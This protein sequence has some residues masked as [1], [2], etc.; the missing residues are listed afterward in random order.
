MPHLTRHNVDGLKAKLHFQ[1]LTDESI[2]P[3]IKMVR[4]EVR[5]DFI[6]YCLDKGNTLPNS[7]VALLMYLG[8]QND[9][10]VK[11]PEPLSEPRT[12]H[13]KLYLLFAHLS[14]FQYDMP[15]LSIEPIAVEDLIQK[16]RNIKNM[17][18]SMAAEYLDKL[19]GTRIPNSSQI[20]M[21]RF[22]KEVQDL[23]SK[24]GLKFHCHLREN[25]VQ[26]LTPDAIVESQ[27]T[28]A[29]FMPT[30]FCQQHINSCEIATSLTMLKKLMSNFNQMQQ[31]CF[32]GQFK[33]PDA[34]VN[35]QAA[36]KELEKAFE[37]LVK[38]S[39][40]SPYREVDLKNLCKLYMK[41]VEII[42]VEMEKQM[43]MIAKPEW[44]LFLKSTKN[45][46]LATVN[47][48]LKTRSIPEGEIFNGDDIYDITKGK[49]TAFQQVS[50]SGHFKKFK[51]DDVVNCLHK[52]KLPVK[53]KESF[54]EFI[55][56]L[57]LFGKTRCLSET[58]VCG[59]SLIMDVD[60]KGHL[61][62]IEHK[63]AKAEETV[64]SHQGLKD[65]GIVNPKA[66]T[67]TALQQ[68]IKSINLTLSKLGIEM[69]NLIKIRNAIEPDSDTFK[70]VTDMIN[71]KEGEIDDLQT[72]RFN[73]RTKY[74]HIKP[75][76]LSIQS[77]SSNSKSNHFKSALS[78]VVSKEQ[79][80]AENS[81][82]IVPPSM[83]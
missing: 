38:P 80:R 3:P 78:N 77:P 49:L 76:S 41:K 46:S 14:V 9:T 29:Y 45:H 43:A 37:D 83:K 75:E 55:K 63:N 71:K 12:N 22:L 21:G 11:K 62:I 72:I 61:R 47:H 16:I 33:L 5:L 23:Y 19:V 56:T 82:Q 1:H 69:S 27:P 50:I 64:L 57:F 35:A 32:N 24:D 34:V 73:L 30:V 48:L 13:Q 81:E 17:T 31:V 70:E 60:Q 65:I 20:S 25:F 52:D 74:G 10:L 8:K 44:Q 7:D 39:S 58:V 68:S 40:S 28:L 6:Q 2:V 54:L 18:D 26:P 42:Q 53:Q 51:K 59:H 67:E 15:G 4:D 79:E 36:I 66:N